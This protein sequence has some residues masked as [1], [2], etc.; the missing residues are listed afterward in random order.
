MTQSTTWNAL[1]VARDARLEGRM[2]VY[3]KCLPEVEVEYVGLSC[4]NC[5]RPHAP[6]ADDRWHRG[7]PSRRQQLITALR[8][9]RVE[10]RTLQAILP[11]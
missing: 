11:R 6:L 8:D 1:Q 7:F 5:S 3:E 2:D 10:W 9:L 4:R